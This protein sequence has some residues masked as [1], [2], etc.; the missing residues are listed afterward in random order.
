[1][2]RIGLLA[3]ELTEAHGWGRYT[4]DLARALADR[5]DVELVIAASEASPGDGGIPHAGYFPVLPA[6]MPAQRWTTPRGLLAVPRLRQ[7]LRGCDV[8]HAVAEHYLPAAALVAGKRPVVVTAHGTYLPMSVQRR[9]G[10]LFRWSAGRAVILPVSRYTAARVTAVLPD[11]RVRVI[12]NGVHAARFAARPATL[13]ARRGPTVLAVGV[14]KPRKG[15]HVLLEAVARVRETVPDVQCVIIGSQSDAAY[16][17]RLREIIATHGL[18]DQAH[19]LGRLPDDE[20]LGWYHA[21]DVFALPAVNV[22]GKFEGF[23]LVYLEAGAA[24]L[25]VIGTLD[26]GAEEAIV[27]GETGL[28][29][30]QEDVPALAEALRRLLTDSDLRARMGAAGRARAEAH[31]WANVARQVVDVYRGEMQARSA[32]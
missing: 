29:V 19:L 27:D 2:I 5:G 28:L 32:G 17:D 24:G 16:V 30:P 18:Q 15:L 3:P 12:P 13:P 11:A 21:A 7:L 22:G 31:S 9:V 6:L 1:M 26:C 4:I 14:N 23:G 25:P 20:L 8:I 10:P